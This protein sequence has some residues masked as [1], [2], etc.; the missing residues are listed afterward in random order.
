MTNDE[1]ADSILMEEINYYL[2]G[3][4]SLHEFYE[5]FVPETWDIHQWAPKIKSTQLNFA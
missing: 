4:Q 1:T 2:N 5:W 3:Q